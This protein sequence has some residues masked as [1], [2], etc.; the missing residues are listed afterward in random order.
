MTCPHSK[1][2]YHIYQIGGGECPGIKNMMKPQRLISILSSVE[3]TMEKVVQLNL[4]EDERR[5]QQV[6]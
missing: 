2:V 6:C 1:V 4:K 3:S 5:T